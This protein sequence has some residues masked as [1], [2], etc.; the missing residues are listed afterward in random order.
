MGVGI[1]SK[2]GRKIRYYF[3]YF[4]LS[5]KSKQKDKLK[6]FLTA[7]SIFKFRCRKTLKAFL[8]HLKKLKF[9]PCRLRILTSRAQLRTIFFTK[10]LLPI[11]HQLLDIF[12]RCAAVAQEFFVELFEVKFI[13]FFLFQF[14]AEIINFFVA[15]KIRTQLHLRD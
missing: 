5:R 15:G 11:K 13:P 8:T 4:F 1:D 3:S 12:N 14:L 9:T 2:H 10:S 7:L 6:R